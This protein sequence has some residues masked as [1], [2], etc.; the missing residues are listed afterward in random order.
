MNIIR[1]LY[2]WFYRVT[3]RPDDR[4]EAFGGRWQG[5]VRSQALELCRGVTGKVLEIGFGSG[6][7]VTRLAS[8]APSAEIWGIDSNGL[9]L[10]QVSRKARDKG[11][12]NVRLATGDARRLAFTDGGFDAVVCINLFLCI[13]FDSVITVLKEMKRVCKPSGRLIFEFRSSRNWLFVLKYKLARFYDETAPYPLYTYEPKQIETLIKEL[14][15]KIV[16][17][18]GLGFPKWCAPIILIEAGR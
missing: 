18:K 7:F 1:S 17:K 14:G 8:Q 9:L 13:D 2:K 5:L 3:S 15:L 6:L 10:E 12:G 4:G 16:S 11:I